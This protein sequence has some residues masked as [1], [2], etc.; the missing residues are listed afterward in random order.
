MEWV[1]CPQCR[2]PAEVTQ[3]MS[4]GST[5]G[6]VEHLHVQ[7]LLRHWFLLPAEMVMPWPVSAPAPLS[8]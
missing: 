5:A 7:C 2:Q 1:V 8:C 4:T 6:R 3:R